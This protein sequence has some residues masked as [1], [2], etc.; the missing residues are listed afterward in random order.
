M[1]FSL[2]GKRCLGERFALQKAVLILAMV[3]QRFRLELA[4]GQNIQPQFL[5]TWQPNML[6]MVVQSRE[7]P[8]PEV[9][10]SW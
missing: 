8:G 7:G 2:G 4:P 6:R 5:G 9:A 1:P 3:M 10:E